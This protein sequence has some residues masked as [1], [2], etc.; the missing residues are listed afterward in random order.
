MS[1]IRP[2]TK[3]QMLDLLK[4]RKES[5]EGLAIKEPSQPPCQTPFQ[6]HQ[7]IQTHT[8]LPLFF[9]PK[10]TGKKKKNIPPGAPPERPAD[11]LGASLG[12]KLRLEG[13]FWTG[14]GFGVYCFFWCLFWLLIFFQRWC[15]CASSLFWGERA[16]CV[17]S[18]FLFFSG[19]AVFLLCFHDVFCFLCFFW[20]ISA[21]FAW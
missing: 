21:V 10:E 18:C 6:K 9:R 7:N 20:S 5:P 1:P 4:C 11:W 19:F 15:R 12:L 17:F 3:N 8:N 2:P 16:F 14:L 13:L